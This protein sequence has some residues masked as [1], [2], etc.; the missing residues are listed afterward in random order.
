M[1]EIVDR[2]ITGLSALGGSAA[3]LEILR[4]WLQRRQEKR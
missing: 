4:P 3:L 1:S 2:A